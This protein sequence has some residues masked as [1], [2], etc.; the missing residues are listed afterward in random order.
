MPFY[1]RCIT[2]DP[3][4]PAPATAAD[5]LADLLRQQV[6]PRRLP[7]AELSARKRTRRPDRTFVASGYG[8][9]HQWQQCN[10]PASNWY[11]SRHAGHN[12]AFI[13]PSVPPPPLNGKQQGVKVISPTD[14]HSE[15]LL[16]LPVL[17]PYG[18]KYL[19]SAW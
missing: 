15:G 13:L 11:N 3:A 5:E 12:I 17:Q 18:E 2:H 16:A 7:P 14:A 9:R 4:D 10:M 1:M 19:N 8:Y 6:I